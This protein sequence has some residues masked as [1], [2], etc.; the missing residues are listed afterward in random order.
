MMEHTLEPSYTYL[1]LE[2]GDHEA[3]HNMMH[4]SSA[5]MMDEWYGGANYPAYQAPSL[6]DLMGIINW[7]LLAGLLVSL[8]RYFWLK[9]G[10]K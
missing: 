9:G 3:M 5:G 7:L 1:D 10:Q 2:G 8:I 6:F 4:G